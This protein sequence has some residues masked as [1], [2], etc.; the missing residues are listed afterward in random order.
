[1]TKYGLELSEIIQ[2][3]ADTYGIP[4]EVITN[5]QMR[6]KPIVEAR[7]IAQ[8]LACKMTYRSRDSIATFFHQR[9]HASVLYGFNKVSVAMAKDPEYKEQVTS[10]SKKL[11]PR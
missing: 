5:T 3:V 6:T 9:D 2:A 4:P 8:Y 1:M 10:L 7:H 11:K